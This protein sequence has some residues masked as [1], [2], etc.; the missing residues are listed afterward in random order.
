MT[1]LYQDRWISCTEDAVVIRWYYLWGAKRIL[2]PRSGPS[3]A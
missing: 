3:H 1:D 2:T